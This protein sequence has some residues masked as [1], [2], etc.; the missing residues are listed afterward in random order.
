MR[1]EKTRLPAIFDRKEKKLFLSV[2]P[3]SKY[4][5]LIDILSDIYSIFRDQESS[6]L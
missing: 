4:D 2:C 3:E 6:N 1:F 5:I